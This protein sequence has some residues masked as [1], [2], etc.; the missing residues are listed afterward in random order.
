MADVAITVANVVKGAG[1]QVTVGVA[2]VTITAGQSIY[3]D[4]TAAGVMKL[5]HAITSAATAV[6]TGIALHGALA[7]QPVA[8]ITSGPFTC[9]GTLVAGKPYYVSGAVAGNIC[10]VADLTTTWQPCSLGYASSTT[11]LQVSIVPTGVTL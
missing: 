11:V 2:G 5:T 4:S 7:N 8:Y 10:P 1:A 3:S 9:G 6:A